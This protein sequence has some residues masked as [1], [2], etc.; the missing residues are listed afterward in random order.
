LIPPHLHFTHLNPHIEFGESNLRIPTEPQSWAT[1]NNYSRRAAVS[2]FGFSGTN[3]HVVI[4]EGPEY[5]LSKQQ[6]KP[7]YLLTL[8]AKHPDSLKQR[9]EDLRNYLKEN[10]EL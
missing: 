4:E 1:Y 6:T 8:S 9:I 3:A 10:P 7:Y 2:S 5:V